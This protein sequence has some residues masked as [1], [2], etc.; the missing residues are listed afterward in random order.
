MHLDDYINEE[1]NSVYVP[2]FFS[3]DKYCT[4]SILSAL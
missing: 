1:N 4:D 2:P 3:H